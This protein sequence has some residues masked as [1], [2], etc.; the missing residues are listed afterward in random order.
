V[1]QTGGWTIDLPGNKVS[2]SDE[3]FDILGYTHGDAPPLADVLKP[4]S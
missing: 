2:W 4:K 3:V 1:T